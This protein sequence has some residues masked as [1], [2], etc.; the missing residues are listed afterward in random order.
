MGS[1]VRIG[2]RGKNSHLVNID[3][4]VPEGTSQMAMCRSTVRLGSPDMV[5][6]G[7]PVDCPT[8]S[9]RNAQPVPG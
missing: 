3:V 7:T 4:K 2:Y 9:S 5:E 1:D 6:R 8:C